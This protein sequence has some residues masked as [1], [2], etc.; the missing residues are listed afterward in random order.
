ML[1]AGDEVG[2]EVVDCLLDDVLEG[3][4]DPFCLLARE[5]LLL[6]AVDVVCRV[7][8]VCRARGLVSEWPAR[9][10]RARDEGDVR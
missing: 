8:E 10:S 4:D 1:C 9:T 3:I 5:P 7:E 2:L 6:E